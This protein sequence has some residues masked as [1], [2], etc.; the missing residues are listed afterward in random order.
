MDRAGLAGRRSRPRHVA[1]DREVDLERARAVT[2]PAVRAG[3][4][5]REPIAEDVGGD[6]RRHV[7]HHARRSAGGRRPRSRARRSRSCR[8]GVRCR[9]RA[10]RR[11]PASRP[12]ATTQPFGVA[13]DDQH[14]PDRAGHRPVEAGE[15]VRRHA[16]P[17][18]LGLLGPPHPA[19]RG[20]RQHRAGTEA[21]QRQRMSRNAQ[22][23][24]GGVGE[25]VVEVRRRSARTHDATA[26]PSAPRV[27]GGPVDRSVQHAGRTV[28]ER[29][30]AVDLG[31]QP[32]EARRTPGPDRPGTVTRRRSDGRPS[33]DRAPGPG[34]SS[35]SCASH[36]RSCRWPRARSRRDRRGPAAPRRRARSAR[37]R[38]RSP[39]S[40]C[41]P[42]LRARCHTRPPLPGWGRPAPRTR[43]GST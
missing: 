32:G 6:R 34:R 20:R 37:C 16:G 3:D 1:L 33:S 43:A 19:Q 40:R 18:R 12:P 35:P 2:E 25:Q 38:R 11:S 39:R 30:G 17:E 8:R 14:Q 15:G 29:M 26:G 28:V 24:L 41:H 22:D 36:R 27:V 7:E 42:A 9:P 10:R 13:G 23:R 21:R 5:I 4:A 31:L